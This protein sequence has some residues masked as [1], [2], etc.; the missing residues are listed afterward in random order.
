[1][2]DENLDRYFAESINNLRHS[3]YKDDDI[4][5]S[6]GYSI[7]NTK[8]NFWFI[9]SSLI[10][11]F[12]VS[13]AVALFSGLFS[14][15]TLEASI[16]LL[17]LFGSLARLIH[18]NKQNN[19]KIKLIL[20]ILTSGI[21]LAAHFLVKWFL[22]LLSERVNNIL[23]TSGLVNSLGGL[24]FNHIISPVIVIV[25]ILII[26]NLLPLIKIKKKQSPAQSS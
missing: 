16:F 17:I 13:L 5:E 25:L 22:S 7:T 11:G 12:I 9:I 18:S 23:G 6:F 21:Y 15:T 8:G 3:G 19:K 4:R 14:A 2:G 10:L 24:N 26:Y 1:M 20:S